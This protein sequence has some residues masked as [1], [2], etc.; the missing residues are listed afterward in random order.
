MGKSDGSPDEA[1]W[2]G[3]LRK[4]KNR[5]KRHSDSKVTQKVM[6]AKGGIGLSQPAG[7]PVPYFYLQSKENTVCTQV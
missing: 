4:T 2:M 1:S 6:G 7:K 3:R 5:D